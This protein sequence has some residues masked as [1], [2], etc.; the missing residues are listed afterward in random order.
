MDGLAERSS[1]QGTTATSCVCSQGSTQ[2]KMEIQYNEGGQGKGKKNACE[3]FS[4]HPLSIG[5]KK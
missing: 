3:I 1:R 2:G 5:F 4:L